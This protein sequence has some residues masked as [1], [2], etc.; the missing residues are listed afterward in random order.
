[1][2]RPSATQPGC[3]GG[4]TAQTDAD[5]PR[6]GLGVLLVVG[7]V[8]DGVS[9]RVGGG[10][11]GALLGDGQSED[12]GGGRMQQIDGQEVSLKG[13][14]LLWHE[15]DAKTVADQ[16]EGG[17]DVVNLDRDCSWRVV[18]VEHRVDEDAVTPSLGEID[19]CLVG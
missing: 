5:P 17:G 10:G 2:F 15:G 18:G 7:L 9:E 3:P 4:A 11:H 12:S 6:G 8:G 14:K 13:Q 19:E 1:M 16:R